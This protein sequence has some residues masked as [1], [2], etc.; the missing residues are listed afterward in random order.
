MKQKNIF[1]GIACILAA[2]FLVVSKLG[3]L[4]EIGFWSLIFTMFLIAVLV[5]GICERNF[6]DILFSIAFILI[7]YDKQLG[8]EA[9]TPWTVLGA[10][11][12]GSCGLSF[13]FPKKSRKNYFHTEEWKQYGHAHH[14][15]NGQE[16]IIDIEDEGHIKQTTKFGASTKYVNCDDFKSA[17]LECSFGAMTV[18][19]DKAQVKDGKAYVN[20]QVS[21]AGME[22][23]IPREWAI[24]NNVRTSL[25]A[26]EEKN[27]NCPDGSVLLTL[28]GSVQ[29]AGVDII[30][31]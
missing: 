17:E 1:W 23:Y 12:F 26:V 27:K 15:G 25:G 7:V 18:Y 16:V 22:L 31:V 30:Y 2:V 20:I 21:F 28:D 29:F 24:N 13:L 11:A 6:T 3:L 19:F 9:L 8:I 4:G 14:G 10:A 5:K